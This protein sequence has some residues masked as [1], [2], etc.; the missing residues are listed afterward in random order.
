MEEI[1]HSA[2]SNKI[3]ISRWFIESPPSL[4]LFN[5]INKSS[6]VNNNIKNR[7][8]NIPTYCTNKNDIDL[9]YEF[10]N[11]IEHLI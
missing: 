9:I 7:I 8:I 4:N 11:N 10:I 1:L 6:F 3:E 5:N 2:R